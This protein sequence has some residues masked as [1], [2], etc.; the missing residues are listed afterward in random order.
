VSSTRLFRV[1]QSAV[2]EVRRSG[3]WLT[4]C[5][6]W[7]DVKP[8][9][10]GIWRVD[11]EELVVERDQSPGVE[12]S[13]GLEAIREVD[14]ARRAGATL[15][16]AF[17]DEW[18][19]KE[20]VCFLARV[21]GQVAGIGWLM[22][23]EHCDV[24]M[25]RSKREATICRLY[26][27]PE[28]RGNGVAKCLVRGICK[29]AQ[30]YEY[31]QIL[32]VINRDGTSSQRVFNAIGFRKVAERTRSGLFGRRYIPRLQRWETWGER[33]GIRTLCTPNELPKRETVP[34]SREVV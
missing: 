25:R 22:G 14:R 12:I 33:L 11:L 19:R 4:V 5:D 3:L 26:T 31:D 29:W 28:F 6:L 23:R 10:F 24:F 18:S 7:R 16:P 27:L 30:E 2:W 32:A 21:R 13:V 1:L 17:Y 15:P 9:T 34:P 20:G 8:R